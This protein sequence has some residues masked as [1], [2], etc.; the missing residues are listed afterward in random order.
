MIIFKSF[1]LIFFISYLVNFAGFIIDRCLKKRNIYIR[2]FIGFSFFI[3]F[4]NFLYFGLNFDLNTIR[5]LLIFFT[6]YIS[7][8][9]S[10]KKIQ[11]FSLNPGRIN[12]NLGYQNNLIIRLLIKLYFIFFG[13]PP[14][15]IAKRIINLILNHKQINYNGKY[16]TNFHLS[17]SKKITYIYELQKKVWEKSLNLFN[18]KKI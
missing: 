6:Y 16:I 13:S 10:F 8:H 9:K 3:I 12:S 14:Y 2:P 17:K 7:N 1:A 4:I 5:I 15:V 11:C 18:I